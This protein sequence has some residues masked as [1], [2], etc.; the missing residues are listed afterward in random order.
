MWYLQLTVIW[1]SSCKVMNFAE[2]NSAAAAA[3][4]AATTATTTTTT[5]IL[6]SIS[7]CTRDIPARAQFTALFAT[8]PA[9]HSTVRHTA[10][11][12]QHCSPHSLQFTALF[13]TQPADHS[14][15]R[16]TACSHHTAK[17]P[18]VLTIAMSRL[19][20]F[21]PLDY[22][23]ADGTSTSLRRPP[24]LLPPNINTSTVPWCT[25]T[26][27]A[28]AVPSDEP[29]CTNIAL[30]LQ[31]VQLHAA[32]HEK[33]AVSQQVQTFPAFSWARRFPVLFTTARHCS[34]S[35]ARLI[36]SIPSQ[37]MHLKIHVNG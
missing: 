26:P 29:T 3:T 16:H 4:T 18:A 19:G 34:L 32:L 27:S 37:P 28:G 35:Y 6:H 2:G 23:P 25:I 36:Q 21:V 8:Q 31:E 20:T 5:T 9:V 15:V 1:L 24:R 13:A 7:G 30:T 11:S 12:S 22:G 17:A 33:L 10:C 14:T